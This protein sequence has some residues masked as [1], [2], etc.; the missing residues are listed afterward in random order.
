M[1]GGRDFGVGNTIIGR[2]PEILIEDIFSVDLWAVFRIVLKKKIVRRE[3]GN[4]QNFLL[5][6]L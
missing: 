5:E 6:E 2:W 1:C 4:E 3:N